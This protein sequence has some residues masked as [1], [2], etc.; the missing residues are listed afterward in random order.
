M[1]MCF[2]SPSRCCNSHSARLSSSS[3]LP[4][5]PPPPPRPASHALPGQPA[6]SESNG[7]PCQYRTMRSRRVGT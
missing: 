3:P 2:C 5:S 6:L 1:S 4:P 7:I